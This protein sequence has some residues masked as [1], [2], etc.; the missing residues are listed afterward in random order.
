MYKFVIGFTIIDLILCV[1]VCTSLIISD[2]Y[3][4]WI[5]TLFHVYVVLTIFTLVLHCMLM[6]C[7]K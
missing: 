3:H 7:I 5:T 2:N 6:L 1:V 4:E